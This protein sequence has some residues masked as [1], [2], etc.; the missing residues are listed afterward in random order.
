MQSERDTN[1]G[2]ESELQLYGKD[3]GEKELYESIN[4][5]MVVYDLFETSDENIDINDF[6]SIDMN[7]EIFHSIL[8]IADVMNL[9]LPEF[10]GTRNAL[11]Y[12]MILENSTED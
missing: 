8:N 3:L 7:S 12:Q 9:T 4:T 6:D 10:S 5:S 2:F 11:A 1:L